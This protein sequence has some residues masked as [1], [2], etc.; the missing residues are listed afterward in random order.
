VSSTPYFTDLEPDAVSRR[1]VIATGAGALLCG[2]LAIATVPM[3]ATWK[4][5]GI[6]AWG[7]TGCRDLWLIATGYKRCARIRMSHE[8]G[9]QAWSPA[10]RCAAATLCAG[11]VVT[12]GFAWLRI[13]FEEGRRLGLLL[14]RTT[15]E[16]HDWRRLQVIWRHLGAGG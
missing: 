6:A 15:S 12:A 3:D 2:A 8:G 14:R 10:G 5:L 7:I 1:I 13:E 16:N 11:S 9:V 4:L